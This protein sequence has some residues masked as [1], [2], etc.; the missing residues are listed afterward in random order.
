[1]VFIL[2]KNRCLNLKIE[3]IMEIDKDSNIK[4]GNYPLLVAAKLSIIKGHSRLPQTKNYQIQRA[5]IAEKIFD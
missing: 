5:Q 3:H 2:Y 1:M 4:G